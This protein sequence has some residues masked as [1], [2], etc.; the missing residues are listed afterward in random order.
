MP[1]P[2]F[3]PT[4]TPQEEY[5]SFNLQR[6][7]QK[8]LMR[9]VVETIQTGVRLGFSSL[10]ELLRVFLTLFS[11]GKVTLSIPEKKKS[12]PGVNKEQLIPHQ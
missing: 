7:H 6:T 4:A 11:Q 3:G 2:D 10:Q 8:L 9:R 1:S 12:L 5:V